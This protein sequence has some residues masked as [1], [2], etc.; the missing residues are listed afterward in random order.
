MRTSHPSFLLLLACLS[1]CATKPAPT[2]PAPPPAQTPAQTPSRTLPSL[3]EERSRPVTTT[4]A[5]PRKALPSLE[6]ERARQRAAPIALPDSPP[7]AISQAARDY[8]DWWLS[9]VQVV[10]GRPTSCGEADGVS[11]V[12]ARQAALDQAVAALRSALNREPAD[13]RTDRVTSIQ[14]GGTFKVR[15][16][17]SAANP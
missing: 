16:R 7:A 8:P 1:A 4:T 10:E 13:L 12:G 14:S 6:E 9:S 5:P 17:V 11:F 3:S 15:V 2:E